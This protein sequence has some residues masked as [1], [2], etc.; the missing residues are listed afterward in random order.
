MVTAVQSWERDIK[1]LLLEQC[2]WV[3]AGMAA[4][5]DEVEQR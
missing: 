1:P 5:W 2:P 4:S 3:T